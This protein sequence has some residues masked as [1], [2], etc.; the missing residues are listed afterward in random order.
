MS[1]T[2]GFF[3]SQ[4]GDRAYDAV[5]MSSIFDGLVGDGVVYNYGDRFAATSGGGTTVNIGSGRAWFDHTWTL[6][7]STLPIALD[8]QEAYGGRKDLIVLEVDADARKN[9]IHKI[10]GTVAQTVEGASYPSITSNQH[11]LCKVEVPQIGD[12]SIR[13]FDVVGFDAS[14]PYAVNL[15]E[16]TSLESLYSEWQN[17]FHDWLSHLANEL[18]ENQAGHLQNEIDT[19]DSQKPN[20]ET[21]VTKTLSSSGWSNGQYSLESQYP[22]SEYDILSILPGTNT[23]EAQRKAWAKADCGG[24]GSSNIIIA[25]GDVP[26]ISINVNICI[27]QKGGVLV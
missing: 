3:N 8:A 2:S 23:T 9:T 1:V 4:N 26:T 16:H 20:Y 27:R 18:D 25:N 21:W 10:T 12:G 17:E 6:N 13:I 7:D 24:Y 14:C 19:L 22:S 11:I 15:I 5:Q